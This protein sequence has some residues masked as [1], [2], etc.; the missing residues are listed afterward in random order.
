MISFYTGLNRLNKFKIVLENI[1]H[2]NFLEYEIDLSKNSL[3]CLVGKNGIGKTTLIKSIQ[4]FK[5]TNTL[6]KVSRLNII[7]EYSKIIYTINDEEYKFLPENFDNKYILDCYKQIDENFQ[8]NI[9]TEFPIPYGK[10]FDVYSKLGGDIGEYIKTKF[11]QESY[12]EKP[13]ELIRILNNIYGTHKYNDLEQIIFKSEKYYIKPLNKQNYIREDDF[14]SGEFMIIQIY[15]LIKNNCKFIAIDELDI[16]LDS[17]AQINLIKE[18]RKLA[19]CYTFNLLFTTHSL[20]IMKMMQEKELYFM[21]EAENKIVI[22]NRSYNYIKAELFQFIGYDRI[23]LVED[24]MIKSYIEY[25]IKDIS[26]FSRYEII[27]IAGS[28]Q[29]VEL[30]KKNKTLNLFGTDKVLTILDGDQIQQYKNNPDIKFLPVKSI[31]KY[32]YEK[33]I[34]LEL[35]GILNG[36]NIDMKSISRA[37]NLK[38]KAKALY[39][40]SIQKKYISQLK[41]FELIEIDKEE[42]VSTFREEIIGF[43]I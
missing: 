42:D 32:L 14:S 37:K 28:N 39:C 13:T 22:E 43:L 7:K 5:E 29:T 9:F 16:S 33:F 18:L 3:F 25:L 15:K 31:E 8:K 21:E 26:L 40:D 1:Q 11:A 20:A 10:R 30:M 17:S 23:I 36:K 38:K 12:N 2:I 6:D 19:E 41:V 34:Y 27:D 4:N 35:Y 24:K